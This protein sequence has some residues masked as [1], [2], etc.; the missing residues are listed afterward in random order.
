MDRNVVE[1]ENLTKR[2]KSRFER[3]DKQE[4]SILSD[5]LKDLKK[6]ESKWEK[7]CEQNYKAVLQYRKLVDLKKKD[8]KYQLTVNETGI[9]NSIGNK[10]QEHENKIALEDRSYKDKL[11]QVELDRQQWLKKHSKEKDRKEKGKAELDTDSEEDINKILDKTVI[12]VDNQVQERL[13]NQEQYITE[14]I[15]A[16]GQ[17]HIDYI[18]DRNRY[19]INS[20]DYAV[21]DRQNRKILHLR[22]IYEHRARTRTR[23]LAQERPSLELDSDTDLSD[24]GYSDIEDF[25]ETEQYL[26]EHILVS[27]NRQPKPNREEFERALREERDRRQR[28]LEAIEVEALNMANPNEH[29]QNLK[30]SV[31][32]VS[33]FHGE[34]GQNASSHLFEFDDFLRAARIEPLARAN[35]AVEKDRNAVHIIND[36]VTTLKGKARIWYDMKI[37][38]DQRTTLGHWNEIKRLFKEHFHPLGSTREQRVKAWKD[39]KWD[40]TTE[41]ID[42]FAYKYKEL[43]N[44]LGLNAGSVFDNFKACIPGQYYV[45][46]YNADTINTAVENL[47]KC[48]AAGPMMTTTTTAPAQEKTDEKLKFMS[49]LESQTEMNKEMYS[50][51]QETLEE[52]FTPMNEAVEH[53]YQLVSENSGQGQNQHQFSQNRHNGRYFPKQFQRGNG[54][55]GQRKTWQNNKGQGFNGS[56]VQCSY[57]KRQRHTVANCILLREELKRRGFKITKGNGLGSNGSN[58]R[59]GQG[60]GRGGFN[61][62][63]P[64]QNRGRQDQLNCMNDSMSDDEEM[65]E[66]EFLLACMSELQEATGCEI[67]PETELNN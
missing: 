25:E 36:F 1:I 61:N 40:P 52:R 48:I 59:P 21:L 39:M 2:E 57:C 38:E 14:Q 18:T 58:F 45:F 27:R 28:E 30:W 7:F 13:H 60:K 5:H 44:S 32:S 17:L 6:L 31:Q 47:K 50:Q 10:V 62:K 35:G 42:D 67:E 29:N 43:G 8:S 20:Y 12:G 64:F 9:W 11:K 34:T 63:N 22:R 37:P 3:F 53:L 46:V 65:N 23:I 55:S 51:F 16:L 49:M 54:N 56:N 24:G 4:A 15:I 19:D 33:K 41:A 26:K 66:E